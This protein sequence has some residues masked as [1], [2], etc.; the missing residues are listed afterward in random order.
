MKH[1]FVTTL[2]LVFAFVSATFAHG[3]S[4]KEKLMPDTSALIAGAPTAIGVDEFM[5][6]VNRYRGPVLVKGVV[7]AVSP[8]RHVIGLI[9]IGEFDSCKVVTCARLTLPIFWTGPMPQV[10][11]TLLVEGEVKEI[12][13]K[14]VFVARALK[15]VGSPQEHSP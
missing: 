12:D 10:K 3:A 13:K 1:F 8:K 9:D 6:N 14:F 15:R 4:Q 5:I 11:D 7:S 2:I